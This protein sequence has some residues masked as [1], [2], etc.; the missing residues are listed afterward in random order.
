MGYNLISVYTEE[1]GLTETGLAGPLATRL[2]KVIRN[3]L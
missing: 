3:Y 2:S 1:S